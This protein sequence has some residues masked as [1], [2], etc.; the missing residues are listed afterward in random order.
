[1]P[2]E[3]ERPESTHCRFCGIKLV[4]RHELPRDIWKDPA[5][6]EA[7]RDREA[8]D[9]AVIRCPECD[10]YGYYNEG[11]SF[12]CRFCDLMFLVVGEDESHPEGYRTVPADEVVR[13]D[14]T[15]TE[16]SDGYDNRTL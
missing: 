1:M 8:Y 12:S 16:C 9:I 5:V 13:L 10:Q 3:G 15:I 7:L 14:D 6:K 4:T 11:S 2:A